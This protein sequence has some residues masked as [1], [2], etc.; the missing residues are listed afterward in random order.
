MWLHCCLIIKDDDKRIKCHS[1]DSG[2]LGTVSNMRSSKQRKRARWKSH[3]DSSG[4]LPVCTKK[5]RGDN[6]SSQQE[7]AHI[8][9]N[10]TQNTFHFQRETRHQEQSS[11]TLMHEGQVGKN[12]GARCFPAPAATSCSSPSIT[13]PHPTRSLA[14]LSRAKLC[15]GKVLVSRCLPKSHEMI[16]DHLTASSSCG[17]HGVSL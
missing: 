17:A 4:L 1:D 16:A 6:Q 9:N 10:C 13:Q 3:S 12:E 15:P 11:A 14:L 2:D 8:F 5:C 7:L